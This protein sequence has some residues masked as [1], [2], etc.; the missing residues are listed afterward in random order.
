VIG[1]AFDGTGLGSDGSIWGGEV[2][3]AGYRDFDRVGH[4]RAVPLPGGDAAIRRPYR[5]ALAHLWA[6]EIEWAEHLPPVSAAR[7]AER[8][9]LAHQF[10]RKVGCVPSSSM[11]RLFDA[12][13][14]L[15]G[16][17]HMASYEAQAAMELEW[18]ADAAHSTPV[19]AFGR[20]ADGID[21]TPVLTALV[22]DLGRG[23]PRADMAAGFH[24]AVADVVVEEA[25]RIRHED[26]IGTVALSGGVF[27]NLRLLHLCREGLVAR[28]F[29]VL[30]HRTVP[31]ND[32]GLALGQAVVA[33]A[34]A[35]GTPVS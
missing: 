18:A 20:H 33:A 25:D 35:A 10:E 28:D 19:Y 2:L 32:G 13:S 14:S 8:I 11:G 30:T 4:L 24:A 3:R 23:V 26:G 27:Q 1:F 5:V 21:A 12:V 16:I 6:A 29:E 22:A 7:A 34:R 17:R 15:L 9:Q 31:P